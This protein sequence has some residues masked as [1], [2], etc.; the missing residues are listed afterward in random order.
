MEFK[1]KMNFIATSTISGLGIGLYYG[2]KNKYNNKY[3]F[4]NNISNLT[5]SGVYGAG[6]G[7]TLSTLSILCISSPILIPVTTLTA[8]VHLL[9]KNIKK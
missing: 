8:G 7:F 4:S 1:M 5:K 3:P 6:L 2:F 9:Y